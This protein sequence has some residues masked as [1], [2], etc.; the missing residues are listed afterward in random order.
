MNKIKQKIL[1]TYTV[2]SIIFAYSSYLYHSWFQ[3]FWND[4]KK[5]MNKT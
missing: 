3:I 2:A 1:G 5:T 4:V